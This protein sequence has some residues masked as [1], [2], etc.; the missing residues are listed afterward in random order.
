MWTS[1]KSKTC[2]QGL[3][4]VKNNCVFSRQLRSSDAGGSL[5]AATQVAGVLGAASWMQRGPGVHQASFGHDLNVA[6]LRLALI[7]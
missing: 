7:K 3:N 4:S 5:G 6:R 2:F 1:R